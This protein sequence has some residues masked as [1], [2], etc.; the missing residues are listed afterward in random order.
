MGAGGGGPVLEGVKTGGAGQQTAEPF[1]LAPSHAGT[2]YL[3]LVV[4]QGGQ[5]D[6]SVLVRAAS[7]TCI[8]HLAPG[9]LACPLCAQAGWPGAAL[10]TATGVWKRMVPAGPVA[11]GGKWP[12]ASGYRTRQWTPLHLASGF[13][14]PA[15]YRTD[16][17]QATYS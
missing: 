10:A 15:S 11:T 3:P 12:V 9:A 13:A 1:G 17:F 2:A 5:R 7:P 16:S 4:E 6:V 14:G 8:Y